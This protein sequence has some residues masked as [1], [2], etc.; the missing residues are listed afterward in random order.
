LF[1][2]LLSCAPGQADLL[3]AEL[4]DAGTL[5]I[6][7]EPGGL[8]AFFDGQAAGPLE[9]FAAYQPVYTPAPDTAWEEETKKSFPPV[10]IGERFFLVPSW[11]TENTPAGRVRLVIEPGMACGTGWHPC[12][13]LCLEAMERHLRPGD[14]VFDVG[15]GSGILSEAARLLG[16]RRVIGCDVD[17]ESVRAAKER[18]LT[19]MFAGSAGAVRG[20]WAD[21]VVANISSAA[22]EELEEDLKRAGKARATRIL[23]GFEADDLPRLSFEV[24]ERSQ[25]DG[26]VCL[27]C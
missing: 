17:E 18:I 7:E 9:R 19:P 6:V 27:V 2:L 4:W 10:E 14:A 21:I 5:G 25:R 3:T 8:R 23:S 24:R 22:A 26:W 20:G 11:S 16:A 1:S 13:Q 12:T 15:S